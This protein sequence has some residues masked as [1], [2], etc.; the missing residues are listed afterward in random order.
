MVTVVCESLLLKP[1]DANLGILKERSF[2]LVVEILYDIAVCIAT[3]CSSAHAELAYKWYYDAMK[4]LHANNTRAGLMIYA[5]YEGIVGHLA[6][7]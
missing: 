3:I 7:G 2:W 5:D 1:C 4:L 6:D